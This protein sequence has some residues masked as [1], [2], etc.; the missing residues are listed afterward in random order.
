MQGPGRPGP[1]AAS[2]DPA[3]EAGTRGR[4]LRRRADAEMFFQELAELDLDLAGTFL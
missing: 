1:G 3:R 2:A 4:A